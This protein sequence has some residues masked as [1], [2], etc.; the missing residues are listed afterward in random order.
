M[1]L[2]ASRKVT[3]SFSFIQRSLQNGDMAWIGTPVAWYNC[4]PVC[5]SLSLLAIEAARLSAH[6]MQFVIGLP[7]SFTAIRLC[8]MALKLTKTGV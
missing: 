4:S 6:I 3:G 1:N 7:F 2:W 5:D 8:I